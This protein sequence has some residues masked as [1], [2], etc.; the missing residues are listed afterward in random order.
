MLYKL[1]K[2]NFNNFI[3]LP[4]IISKIILIKFNF[5]IFTFRL[6]SDYQFISFLFCYLIFWNKSLWKNKTS[7]AMISHLLG[8]MYMHVT[9]HKTYIVQMQTW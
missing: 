6:S 3:A 4:F 1:L 5:G 9:L 7:S 2:W 8:A